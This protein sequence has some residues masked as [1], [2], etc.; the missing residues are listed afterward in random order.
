M[1]QALRFVIHFV[2]DM[3][4]PLHVA[5][6]G[7]KGGNTRHVIF[8]GHPDKLHWA[9]DTGLLQD[10]TRDPAAFAAELESPI[11]PRDQAEWQNGSIEDLAM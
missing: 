4:Q 8:R 3:Q 5:D 2:G 10:I 7:D 1:A 11:T 9:W 6:N